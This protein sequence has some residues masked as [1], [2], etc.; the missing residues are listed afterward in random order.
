MRPAPGLNEAKAAPNRTKQHRFGS[1]T[2]S[3]NPIGRRLDRLEAKVQ[4]RNDPDDGPVFTFINDPRDPENA[5]RLEEAEQFRRDNPN[6]LIVE[7]TI[8]A[9]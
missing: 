6:G 8:V 5:K 2:T 3:A 7:H 9:Q 1:P 4:K